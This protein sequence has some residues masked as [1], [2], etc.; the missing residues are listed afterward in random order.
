MWTGIQLT[1]GGRV[2]F[3]HVF[4]S[5]SPMLCCSLSLMLYWTVD[6]VW[7]VCLLLSPKVSAFF[8]RKTTNQPCPANCCIRIKTS[9]ST[10]LGYHIQRCKTMGNF[11]HIEWQKRNRERKRKRKRKRPRPRKATQKNRL[12]ILRCWK[13]WFFRYKVG[14]CLTFNLDA[15][16]RFEEE[17]QTSTL[18]STHVAEQSCKAT[19]YSHYPCSHFIL[20]SNWGW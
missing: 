2:H 15:R 12:L 1:C 8:V 11:E 18:A 14:I 19:W 3:G 10:Y 20:N 17:L 5:T 7:I 13:V 9:T 6:G 16:K 4:S